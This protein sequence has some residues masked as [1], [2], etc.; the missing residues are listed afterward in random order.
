MQAIGG[1]HR[2]MLIAGI[3]IKLI[4]LVVISV[5]YPLYKILL[6]SDKQKYAFDIVQL[7]NQIIE[8]T[9]E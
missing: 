3:V 8:A 5:N 6:E 2:P 1:N 9:E 7:A 4:G